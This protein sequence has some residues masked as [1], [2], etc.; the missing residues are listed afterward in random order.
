MGG[1]AGPPTITIYDLT[2]SRPRTSPHRVLHVMRMSG[3]G[4]A[5]N[6][7][8]HVIPPLR[9]YGW[10]SD[11]LIPTPRPDAVR[12]L[13]SKFDAICGDVTV[14]PM[15]YDLNAR[16]A[17]SLVRRLRSRDY[18]IVNS[19]L[20]HADWHV[21]LASLAA[22]SVAVVSTKHNDDPFRRMLPFRL[23]EHAAANR[24]AT[25]ITI[26]ESLRDFTLRWSRP[27]SPVL[28]VHYGMEASPNCPPTR[29]EGD[30]PTLLAVAR[31]APQKGLDIV[32]R[33]MKAVTATVP[34][35]RL[36]IAGEGPERRSLEGLV[37][38]LG[39]GHAV[40]LLGHR[41][42]VSE[43]MRAAWLLVHPA[44][45][46]GF[47]LVFLEAMREALPIVSTRVGAVPEIVVDR[48]TGRLVPPE[49]SH[50]LA[51]AIIEMLT[52]PALRRR[53]GVEGF[54]RLVERFSAER[55]AQLTAAVYD[56]ALSGAGRAAA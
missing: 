43:L 47:G 38:S 46:E 53:A 11:L 15:K 5:E 21:A 34:T 19:H 35:A 12:V 40:R 33:A 14:A 4:G 6:Y 9:R 24:C 17:L 50:A 51:D 23:V 26:S 56:R 7:L 31:L 30:T 20:V 41:S 2:E 44:R 29:S 42:D 13:V 22:P 37:R 10:D 45:W 54:A 25:I 48:V 52:N 36:L 8:R 3:V 1:R 18:V 27:R 49:H 32:I 55:M 16:L 39:L 28:A